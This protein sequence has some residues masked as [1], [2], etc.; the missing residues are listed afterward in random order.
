MKNINTLF[1]AALMLLFVG[2]MYA[3][4]NNVPY[5][6]E[7]GTTRTANNVTVIT[8]GGTQTLTN[9]WYML[10]GSQTFFGTLTIS[11]V[12]HLILENGCNWSISD[13]GVRVNRTDN[14]SIYAQTT[15][16]NMGRLST[17]GGR[18]TA[19]IGGGNY[20]NGGIIT[21]NGGTINATGGE[22]GA[23]IGGRNYFGN[24]HTIT[25]NSGI[26][27]AVGSGSG[28]GIGGADGGNGG[29]ITIN[30][31]TINAVGTEGA[32]IGGGRLGDGGTITINGGTVTASS[33]G[34]GAGIG[35]GNSDGFDNYGAGGTI[36]IS[37]GR[38][39][40]TSGNNGAGIGGG[41]RA[42]GG[43]ILISGGTV[44]A[45][46]GVN[47][48]A[49]IGGGGR[50]TMFS[51]FGGGGNVI[52]TGGS[53]KATG[54]A[55]APDIGGGSV[56]TN[57]GTLRNSSGQN[58]FLNR[59]AL[60]G[61]NNV[62]SI[63][64]ASYG[65]TQY[66]VKDVQAD[67]N[68]E[69]YF[70]LPDDMNVSITVATTFAN[71]GQTYVTP[72]NHTA[73][74]RTLPMTSTQVTATALTGATSPAAGATPSTTINDGD[75]FTASLSW[76]DNPA[77]FFCET[78]YTV[79]ITLTARSGFTFWG[80]FA[81]TA[82][83]AGFTVNDVAPTG[84]ISNNGATLVF[85]VQF[86][87]M[88]SHIFGVLPETQAPTCTQ[89]GEQALVCSECGAKKDVVVIPALGHD[90]GDWEVT[91]EPTITSE[92]SRTRTCRHDASHTE[93]EAIPKIPSWMVAVVNGTGDANY[94]EGTTVTIVANAPP[95][96]RRFARWNITP[97]VT[98]TS[99]TS[100]TSSSATFTMPA[101]AVTA[102]AVFE[103]ITSVETLSET[104]P[105]RAWIR[106]GSL[107]ITG[108][109]AGKT[110]SVYTATGALVYQN[111]VSTTET[112]ISLA[113]Q[114]VYIVRQGEHTVKV[115]FYINN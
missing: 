42:H 79:T 26:I 92:G 25:I 45:N 69:L 84:W 48:G 67:A 34:S 104:N 75:G 28:A 99:G 61:I 52:I 12:V 72:S 65:A 73:A 71:F 15:G 8:V 31:G 2:A 98:F 3:Q 97:S 22:T 86:P 74:I 87:A 115:S 1:I 32:G 10:R 114:G 89:A 78:Q 56:S 62:V 95:T 59:L 102:T 41:V 103:A 55:N 39:T 93:T 100:A 66:G 11:G 107:H 82:Q 54:G 57:Q 47:G 24:S 90:W 30:G 68:G 106:N 33:N 91:L 23:G 63:T 113:V 20:Y 19:G 112:D 50:T 13:G 108:L 29:S 40:A 83:I 35:G 94:A 111:I 109:T 36:T 27:N 58:V 21:I 17:A 44:T 37:G 16:A 49:G 110:L 9:G 81:N 43:N 77:I 70:Y 85:E 101:Q 76:N 18:N 105:L 4:T 64:S 6:D 5:I 51:P 60:S 46:S 96:N 80:G 38:V 88:G 7:N 53:I 14:L